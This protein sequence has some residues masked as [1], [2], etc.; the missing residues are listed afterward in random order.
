LW[1]SANRISTLAGGKKI[2]TARFSGGSII[3]LRTALTE[4]EEM[5]AE[6]ERYTHLLEQ[7]FAELE[8]KYRAL[9]DRADRLA[10]NQ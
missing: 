3:E 10:A 6:Q 8:A 7:R 2:S 9:H 4:L 5:L 1:R